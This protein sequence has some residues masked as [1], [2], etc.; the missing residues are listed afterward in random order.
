MRL[1]HVHVQVKG[2]K[3]CCLLLSGWLRPSTEAG[4]WR[5]WFGWW[6]RRWRKHG[7]QTESSTS[8][9]GEE[10]ARSVQKSF[11]YTAVKSVCCSEDDA[12]WFGRA[13]CLTRFI[14]DYD[15]LQFKKHIEQLH[16]MNTPTDRLVILFTLIQELLKWENLLHLKL[17]VLL[18]KRS[19]RGTRG[20]TTSPSQRV[21]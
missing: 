18:L 6:R 17:Q 3:V 12:V 20:L 13:C 2:I 9:E 19:R 11:S 14:P 7:S 5:G 16:C 8:E 1:K 15:L 21:T 10:G 4:V